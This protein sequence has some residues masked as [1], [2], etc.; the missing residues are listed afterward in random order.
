MQT[1]YKY[2]W[3]NSLENNCPQNDSSGIYS[4][5]F[6][7]FATAKD[8]ATKVQ[9]EKWVPATTKSVACFILFSNAINSD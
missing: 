7:S 8:F 4:T 2:N 5:M 3:R 9:T 1:L 6:C